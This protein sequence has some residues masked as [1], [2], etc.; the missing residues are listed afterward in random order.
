MFTDHLTKMCH[1]C[2]CE[3]TYNS[4]QVARMFAHVVFRLHGMPTTIV[5]DR[6]VVMDSSFWR[7]LH[8]ILG[9]KLAMSTAYHPQ[10]DGQTERMNR[11]MEEMLRAFVN[12]KHDNWDQLLVTAEFAYND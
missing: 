9:T 6:D 8:A 11:T 2:P 10:T 5:S 1:F 4:A 12:E 7:S 3:M